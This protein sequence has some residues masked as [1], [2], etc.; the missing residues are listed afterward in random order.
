MDEQF[1]HDWDGLLC[2]VQSF[3]SLYTPIN[4]R[5]KS[6]HNYIWTVKPSNAKVAGQECPMFSSNTFW[7]TRM[8]SNTEE[9]QRSHKARE[10]Q[11][12]DMFTHCNDKD[13]K[14]METFSRLGS[15][16]YAT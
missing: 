6:T 7:G 13:R 11:P 9:I 5:R 12:N 1:V 10:M 3:P 14:I 15:I 16:I 8:D 4:H 2:V